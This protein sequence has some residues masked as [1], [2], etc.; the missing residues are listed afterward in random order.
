MNMRKQS[1]RM[2]FYPSAALVCYPILPIAAFLLA[3]GV[4]SPVTHTLFWAVL[5]L[6]LGVAAELVVIRLSLCVSVSLSDTVAE[7]RE[8]VRVHITVSN[9]GPLPVPYL[10]AELTRTGPMG[11]DSA[12]KGLIM[13]LLPFSDCSTEESMELYFRGE[14][15]IESDCIV[16]SDLFRMVYMRIPC[17]FSET[18]TVLP[19]RGALPE[20]RSFLGFAEETAASSK[21]V[22]EDDGEFDEIRTYRNG[23]S[24]KRIHWKLSSKSEEPL[25]RGLSG[26]GRGGVCILCDL[27]PPFMGDTPLYTP[28]AEYAHVA[29]LAVLDAV[30]EGAVAAAG[31]ELESGGWAEVRW[32]ES[33]EPVTVRVQTEG[34]LEALALRMSLLEADMT[35]RQ[36]KRL[37]DDACG[38]GM[39]VVIV[40]PAFD[41]DSVSEYGAMSQKGC[42]EVVICACPG[43]YCESEELPYAKERL[44]KY[45][46]NV[47]TV[48]FVL[49]PAYN[50]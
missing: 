9:K 15:K 25:V 36:I 28:C 44:S 18:V 29:D 26:T 4:K 8:P 48:P 43:L 7:K 13:S 17:G 33:G 10:R 27:Y 47:R 46:I 50:S 14:Y 35:D 2:P 1:F 42:G 30:T 40:S 3:Q 32:H 21:S 19:S 11:C 22:D 49:P 24:P 41:G 20:A 6:P 5:L 23:D 45:G 37:T 12:C 34:D 16:V 39:P 38:Q 31:R